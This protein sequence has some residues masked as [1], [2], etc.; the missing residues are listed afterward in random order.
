MTGPF[1]QYLQHRSARGLILSKC[2]RGHFLR[3]PNGCWPSL[4]MALLVPAYDHSAY[5]TLRESEFRDLTFE[6]IP[7]RKT[8]SVY[9]DE[10]S[11]RINSIQRSETRSSN[12]PPQYPPTSRS[13]PKCSSPTGR[14]HGSYVQISHSDTKGANRAIWPAPGRTYRSYRDQDTRLVEVHMSRRDY[15]FVRWSMRLACER[16]VSCG[17]TGLGFPM[18]RTHM[19]LAWLAIIRT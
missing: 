9:I 16:V 1:K 10:S 3:L 14:R 8:Q 17:N 6:S 2:D 5:V 13:V 12:S 11:W 7:S 4:I 19:R 18:A 15:S